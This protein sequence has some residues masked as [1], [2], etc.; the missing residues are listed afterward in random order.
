MRFSFTLGL[1]V[2]DQSL[3]EVLLVLV[4]IRQPFLLRQP[5]PRGSQNVTAL[6]GCC[7]AGFTVYVPKPF[8]AESS[9]VST[10]QC[11]WFGPLNRSL[12][13]QTESVGITLSSFQTDSFLV[14]YNQFNQWNSTSFFRDPL[15]ITTRSAPRGPLYKRCSLVRPTNH[16]IKIARDFGQ[17]QAKFKANTN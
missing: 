10:V 7:T 15:I 9:V 13:P 14:L 17:S 1:D 12:D 6:Y 3:S 16:V 11:V 2:A 5:G 4:Q 8:W